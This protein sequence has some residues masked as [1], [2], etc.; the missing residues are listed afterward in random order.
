MRAG[1]ARTYGRRAAIVRLSAAAILT[2]DANGCTMNTPFP[3]R[4]DRKFNV[5]EFFALIDSRPEE[6]HWQLIDGV[7]MCFHRRHWCTN[8]LPR[9]SRFELNTYLTSHRQD[10]P[11]YQ[12]VGLI[13][14]D[15]ELFRP[16]ADVAVLDAM[17]DYE[18][19]ANK[20]YFVAEVLSDS[21]TDKDIAVKRQRY[22]Q[23]PRQPLLRAHRAEADTAGGARAGRRVAAGRSRR[24]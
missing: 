18:L 8:A 3:V 21:N 5:E 4:K 11:A 12:G 1:T 20:F 23:H 10:V 24:P 13:V 17:A 14:P 16:E 2:H 15:A 22:L 7:A 19:Y 9:I 6:E